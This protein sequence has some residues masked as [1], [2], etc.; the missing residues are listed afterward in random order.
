M[1][2]WRISYRAQ[3]KKA[4]ACLLASGRGPQGPDNW[5]TVLSEASSV[6][7]SPLHSFHLL[8][9]QGTLATPSQ[10]SLLE[11]KGQPSSYPISRAFLHLGAFQIQTYLT[12]EAFFDLGFFGIYDLLPATVSGRQVLLRKGS[13]SFISASTV[14][15]SLQPH[16]L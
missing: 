16:E 6:P 1:R 13:L 15:N 2:P 3:G 7:C 10:K 5:H 12:S 4:Q 8:P 9:P 11:G 14:S